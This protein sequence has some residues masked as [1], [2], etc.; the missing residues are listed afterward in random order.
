[1]TLR[2]T[3]LYLKE[4]IPMKYLLVFLNLVPLY[5]TAQK[6]EVKFNAL[7]IADVSY[8]RKLTDHFSA[9]IHLGTGLIKHDKYQNK[10]FFKSYGRYYALKNQD[11][12]KFFIQLSY[13]YNS[14]HY[15]AY[16]DAAGTYPARTHNEYSIMG[17]VGYKFLFYKRFTLDLYVDVGPELS[18]PNALLAIFGD[19]G[20]NL[21]YRKYFFGCPVAWGS[22]FKIQ[23]LRFKV[24]RSMFRC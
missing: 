17:G 15:F 13:A 9:G 20:L 21:G 14:D 24:Q 10:L 11:F 18:N 5:S 7:K 23:S 6:N 22:Q 2:G 16:Q 8:E 12:N 19:A 3:I 4:N 1:M